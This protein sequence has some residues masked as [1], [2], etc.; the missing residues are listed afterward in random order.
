MIHGARGLEFLPNGPHPID[1]LFPTAANGIEGK[2]R[3]VKNV[4]NLTS[5]DITTSKVAIG[6][7][8]RKKCSPTT[9]KMLSEGKTTKKMR[10]SQ[11]S[12]PKIAVQPGLVVRQWGRVKKHNKK[13]W[14]MMWS[15]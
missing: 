9:Q 3:E 7:G 13:N 4:G 15:S 11:R 6:P 5:S 2:K 10:S 8:V 12:D 1:K 14:M